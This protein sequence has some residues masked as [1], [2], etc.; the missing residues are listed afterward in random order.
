MKIGYARVSSLNRNLNRQIEMLEEFGAEK[1]FKEK[2]SGATVD[3]RSVFKEVLNFV[4]L[5]DQ[6]IVESID[7][8]GK[9]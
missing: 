5:D 7:W 3:E 4:R 1:I 2:R 6:L 9:N 8:L